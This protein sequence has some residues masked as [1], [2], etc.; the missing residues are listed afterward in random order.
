MMPPAAP[1]ARAAGGIEPANRL[2]HHMLISLRSKGASWAIKTLFGLLIISFAWW[3]IPET[4]RHLQ[5][6]PRAASVGSTKITPDELRHAVDREMRRLQQSLGSQLE[7]ETMRPMLVSQT[8]DRL[9]ERS[10]LAAYAKE[11]GVVAPDDVLQQDIRSD[12]AFRNTAG[13]F[14]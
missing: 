12:P 9:I 8:L 6:Q 11:A 4:F 14:D 3:G 7:P 5:P 1:A 2:R 10:L 13:Q